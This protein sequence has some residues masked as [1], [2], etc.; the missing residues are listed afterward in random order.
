[1]SK[2]FTITNTCTTV[3]TW[4]KAELKVSGDGVW[5]SS[6]EIA[7]YVHKPT[8]TVTV[9]VDAYT[10]TVNY[11]SPKLNALHKHFDSVAE[12][13]AEFQALRGLLGLKGV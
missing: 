13:W 4:G 8:R 1:M 10:W 3:P 12:G 2:E 5:A 6:V 11:D 7:V 9:Q